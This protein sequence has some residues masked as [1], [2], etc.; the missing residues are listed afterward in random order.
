MAFPLTSHV[1]LKLNTSIIL[2][3]I[4]FAIQISRP[5]IRFYGFFSPSIAA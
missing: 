1:R 3:S 4:L 2:V 5:A